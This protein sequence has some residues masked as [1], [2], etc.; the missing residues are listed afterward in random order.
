VLREVF[1]KGVPIFFSRPAELSRPTHMRQAAG[2]R[3]LDAR[4][5]FNSQPGRATTAGAARAV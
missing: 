5:P 3:Q 2:L 4:F 1:F